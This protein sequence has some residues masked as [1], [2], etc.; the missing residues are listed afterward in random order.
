MIA[1]DKIIVI[2]LD[3]TLCETKAPH[4]EYADVKPREEIVQELREYKKQGFYVIVVS[5][6]NM[7]TFEGNIGKINAITLKIILEWLDKHQ[8]PY[9]E[10]HV[11]RPWCGEG[12]FY[13]DNKTIRPDEFIRL[14]SEEINKL[15][16][17]EKA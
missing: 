4:Q 17:G 6:R 13:V 11:G 10:V 1:R 5:S 7:K 8:I 12:G 9:D 14:S 3:G 16:R 2:D 15:L